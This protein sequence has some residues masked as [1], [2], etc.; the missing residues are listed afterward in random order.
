MKKIIFTFLLVLFSWTVCFG[1][2]A[3][4][5]AATSK[6]KV[7]DNPKTY[8][9]VYDIT[10]SVTQ[11]TAIDFKAETFGV[12]VKVIDVDFKSDSSDV[13]ICI[14]E[15]DNQTATDV[16]ARVCVEGF[17]DGIRSAI[18][19]TIVTNQDGTTDKVFYV[20]I[21]NQTATQTGTSGELII[22]VERR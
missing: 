22:T 8:K 16:Y 15:K 3:I 2:A 20:N 12:S 11:G 5:L 6:E 1:Q 13:D 10:D 17:G 14:S 9:Y 18:Q 19:P 7:W 4:P 21:S